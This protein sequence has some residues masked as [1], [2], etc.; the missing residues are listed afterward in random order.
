MPSDG[1]PSDQELDEEAEETVDAV[2]ARLLASPEQLTA[3][4]PQVQ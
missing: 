1:S 3:T 2:V 4:L